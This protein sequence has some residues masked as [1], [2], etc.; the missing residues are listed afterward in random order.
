MRGGVLEEPDEAVLDS[1]VLD[2]SG[3][4]AGEHSNDVASPFFVSKKA[5]AVL[6]HALLDKYVVPFASKTGKHAPDGRVVYLDGYAGPGRYDDGTPGSPALILES[7]APSRPSASSTAT[8]LRRTARTINPCR[9]WSRK[10]ASRDSQ[11]MPCRAAPKGT[12]TTSWKQPKGHR[13]SPSS[14]PSVSASPS[15]PSHGGSSEAAAQA[16]CPPKSF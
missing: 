14:T 15:T 16:A 11:P 10:P 7:A 6:K 9:P 5:A 12:W 8:S 4:T 13:C 3:E 2:L 1:A